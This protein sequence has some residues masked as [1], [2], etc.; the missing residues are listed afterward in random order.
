MEEK[1]VNDGIELLVN[2]TEIGLNEFTSNFLKDTIG[3]MISS[4]KTDVGPCYEATI[5]IANI[6][7]EDMK[8]AII[9]LFV[10]DVSIEINEFVCNIMK[11]SIYGMI[12]ALNTEKFGITAIKSI[13]IKIEK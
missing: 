6:E 11:E 8:N 10:N 13:N 4:L 9:E 3:G 5:E 7:N 1:Y 2:S 12:K